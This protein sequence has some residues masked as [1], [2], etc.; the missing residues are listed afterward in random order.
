MS[1][2]DGTRPS[3][4]D[5]LPSYNERYTAPLFI[6]ALLIGAHLSYSNLAGLTE[7]TLAVGACMA[8]DLALARL[9]RGHWRNLA[10]PYISGISVAILIRS[11]ALWV[12]PVAGMVSIASKYALQFRGRHI[13]NPTNF[14]VVAMLVLAR[15][16]MAILSIQ[17]SNFIW[18]IIIIWILGFYVVW[19]VNRLHI[20]GSYVAAFVAF[21]FLRSAITGNHVLTEI[22]PVTGPMYQ[23]FAFFMIT[24]PKTTVRSRT[25][26]YLFV[27]VVAA[28]EVIFRLFEFIYAPFYALF[29]VGP[30]AM[31]I[32]I[33]MRTPDDESDRDDEENEKSGSRSKNGDG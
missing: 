25:G 31:M 15:D 8:L 10:S 13:W 29:L 7:L 23:L 27:L 17:W 16:H 5:Y 19:R 24:D 22:S 33:T 26:Q 4:L 9:V 20:T 2:D 3:I 1:S 14:G 21:A 12:F 30:L 18:P 28:V 32:E 11:K 6:T